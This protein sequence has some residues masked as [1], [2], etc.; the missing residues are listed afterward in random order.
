MTEHELKTALNSY[1]QSG[2]DHLEDVRNNVLNRLPQE[3]PERSRQHSHRFGFA[4]TAAAVLL[5]IVF[6]QTPPGAAAVNIVREQVTEIIELLFPPKDITITLEGTP[7][8]IPHTAQG[9]E[10]EDVSKPGFAL[11]VDSESYVMTEE[12]GV[13]Y[14]KPMISLPTREEVQQNNRALLEGLSPEE[15]ESEVDRLL[16]EQEAFYSNLLVCEIEII[17][18][19]DT[20]PECAAGELRNQMFES[21][22]S[23]SKIVESSNPVGLSFTASGG[24]EWDS[25]QEEHYFVGD[26]QQGTFRL[27]IRYFLEAAE[28][29]GTR[30]RTMVGTFSVIHP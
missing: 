16:A 20:A 19:P 10:P 1:T 9:Q 7:E 12:N 26:G 22:V 6:L 2:M 5:F 8:E 17:H 29:H 27:T 14:V 13:T 30:L 21:W 18:L 4:A 15:T 3:A 24:T 11:Y 25:P 23:V 28:G